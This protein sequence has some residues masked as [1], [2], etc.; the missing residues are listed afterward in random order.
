MPKLPH[1]ERTIIDS[2]KLVGYCL[3][4]QHPDG[5]HKAKVFK[6][7][8]NLGIEDADVLKDALLNA[9]HVNVAM[10]AK[11]NAYGKKYIIEFEMSHAGQTAIVRSAWIVRNN[12]NFPR[13]VTCYILE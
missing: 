12:E 1:P 10:L 5:Q 6:S 9:V 11:R 7:A 4:T 13:L 3:N 8:L 2:G